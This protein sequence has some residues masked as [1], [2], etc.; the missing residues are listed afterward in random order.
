MSDKYKAIDNSRAHFVT[1]TVISWIDLFTRNSLRRVVTDSLQYCKD[2][3]GLE[4][5]AWCLM[6][7]HLHMICKASEEQKLSDIIRDFK[8]HTSKKIVE[9]IIN[10][11]ESRREWLLEAFQKACEHLKRDQKYKV[12]Q[13][14]YHAE[15]IRSNSFLESKSDYIHQNPV[16]D[17]IVEFAEDYMY[18]SARK[19][20]ERDSI[21]EIDLISRQW[22][23]I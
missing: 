8:T 5:N 18:S 22:K 19:Y 10:K 17:G 12:W 20:A 21:L 9:T 13:N 16:N 1:I 2:K 7:S 15:E 23:T 3:K 11:P 4:V 14:G 6:P